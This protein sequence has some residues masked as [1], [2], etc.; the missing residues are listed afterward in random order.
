MMFADKELWTKKETG[1]FATSMPKELNAASSAQQYHSSISV[2]FLSCI[3]LDGG[4]GKW[5]AISSS[6]A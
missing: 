2:L 5:P 6:R 3:V 1:N 4:E